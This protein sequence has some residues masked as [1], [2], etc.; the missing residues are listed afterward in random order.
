LHI[1]GRSTDKTYL[2]ESVLTGGVGLAF[3]LSSKPN[4]SW[5]TAASSAPPSFGAAV[6]R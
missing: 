2:P 3:S 6:L 4:K 5:G 1:D